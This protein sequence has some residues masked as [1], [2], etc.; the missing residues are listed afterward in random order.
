MNLIRKVSQGKR[1][2]IYTFDKLMNIETGLM[3]MKNT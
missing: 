2:E 1:W 3:I